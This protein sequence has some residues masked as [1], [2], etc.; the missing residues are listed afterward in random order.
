MDDVTTDRQE[1]LRATSKGNRLTDPWPHHT[2]QL[3]WTCSLSPN[4]D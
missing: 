4:P 3:P 2:T 1:L